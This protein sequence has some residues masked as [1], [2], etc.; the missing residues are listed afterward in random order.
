MQLNVQQVDS[1]SKSVNDKA[2][3]TIA[4]VEQQHNAGLSLRIM[5][6]GAEDNTSYT[7]FLQFKLWFILLSLL[8]VSWL[9]DQTQV[10]RLSICKEILAMCYDYTGK[11]APWRAKFRET[12][13]TASYP[14][15]RY[16]EARYKEGRLY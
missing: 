16:N 9:S 5:P 6:S 13:S 8:K 2:W 3:M 10:L 12:R 15:P 4:I 7:T 14:N 1:Y 11:S